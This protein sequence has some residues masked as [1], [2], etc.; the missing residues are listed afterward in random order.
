MVM[1]VDFIKLIM[2]LVLKI[3][4]MDFKSFF[5]VE[6]FVV[7]MV[8]FVKLIMFVILKILMLDF[9]LLILVVFVLMRCSLLLMVNSQ[10]FYTYLLMSLAVLMVEVLMGKSFMFIVMFMSFSLVMMLLGFVLM[11]MRIFANF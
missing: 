2:F 3:M 10:F 11:L 8:D 7:M 5:L 9:R 6:V 4:I 1:M